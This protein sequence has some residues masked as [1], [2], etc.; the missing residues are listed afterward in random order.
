[1]NN[2][3]NLPNGKTL[4]TGNKLTAEPTN[5]NQNPDFLKPGNDMLQNTPRVRELESSENESLRTWL[6]ANTPS[7]SVPPSLLERLKNIPNKD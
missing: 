2:Q 1:M 3:T 5:P 7:Q 6:K 4:K